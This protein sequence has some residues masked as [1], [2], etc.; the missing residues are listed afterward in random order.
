MLLEKLQGRQ[1]IEEHAHAALL[2]LELPGRIT[3]R[4]WAAG[5][6]VEDVQVGRGRQDARHLERAGKLKNLVGGPLL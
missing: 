3:G 2:S 5:H 6:G 1:G 4:E